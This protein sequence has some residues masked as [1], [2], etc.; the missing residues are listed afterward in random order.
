MT[1]DTGCRQHYIIV[2]EGTGKQPAVPAAGV[3]GPICK[4]IKQNRI[5]S[6]E[7]AMRRFLLWLIFVTTGL[8]VVG[9]VSV[10]YLGPLAGI[11]LV[12]EAV[13]IRIPVQLAD[14]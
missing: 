3:L 12:P 11:D 5:S 1:D 8:G 13:E 4:H 2:D 14:D 10:S 9:L 6:A 7:W